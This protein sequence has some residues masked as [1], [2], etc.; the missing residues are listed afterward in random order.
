[1]TVYD[2]RGLLAADA[3]C[4]AAVPASA[5][6]RAFHSANA[7]VG[8]PSIPKISMSYPSRPGSVFVNLNRQCPGLYA[9]SERHT[10]GSGSHL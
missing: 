6:F 8:T 5:S 4:N 2:I 9:T 10:Y 7:F 3:A 1:M